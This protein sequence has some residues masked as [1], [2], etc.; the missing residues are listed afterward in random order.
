M[1]VAFCNVM[2]AA[3]GLLALRIVLGDLRSGVGA[4]RVDV[5]YLLV[6]LC[7]LILARLGGLS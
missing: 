7:F 4:A 1:W 2:A 5:T 6:A 3:W